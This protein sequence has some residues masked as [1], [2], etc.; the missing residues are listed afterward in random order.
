MLRQYA[1]IA[2]GERGVVVGPHGDF[3]W[4]RLPRWDSPAVF[5]SLLGGAAVLRGLTSSGG[6]MVAAATMSPP[7]RAKAVTHDGFVYRYRPNGRDLGEA[8]GA[9]VLCSFVMALAEAAHLIS[10]NVTA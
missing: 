10:K 3:C 9:F 4:M 1:L 2:D 8:E 6:G 5:S 7:E